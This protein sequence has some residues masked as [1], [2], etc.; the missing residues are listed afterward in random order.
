MSVGPDGPTSHR[1]SNLME[2]HVSEQ[3]DEERPETTE[4]PLTT[5]A[6]AVAE[7]ASDEPV[8]PVPAE[9]PVDESLVEAHDGAAE[10]SE[11]EAVAVDGE[12]FDTGATEEPVEEVLAG[13]EAV[14]DDEPKVR[15]ITSVP[16]HGARVR[17]TPRT[18]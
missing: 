12:A 4:E 8:A 7:P 11:P 15:N 17:V 14:G 2:Q 3:Y 5:E 6:D 18:P 10:G 16:R 13:V 9:E 1:N